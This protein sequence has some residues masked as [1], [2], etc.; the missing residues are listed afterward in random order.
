MDIALFV[1]S[2]AVNPVCTEVLNQS[3]VKLSAGAWL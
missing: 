3:S 2:Q 1:V